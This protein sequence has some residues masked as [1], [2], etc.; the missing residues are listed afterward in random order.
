MASLAV[1]G[2]VRFFAGE[3]SVRLKPW[4]AR[5]RAVLL[6]YS[7]TDRSLRISRCPYRRRFCLSRARG[8]FAS[9]CGLGLVTSQWFRAFPCSRVL[10]PCQ[11][12]GTSEAEIVAWRLRKSF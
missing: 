2:T 11:H 12:L 1:Q 7:D 5:L 9:P 3:R 4:P 6:T 8:S 10:A